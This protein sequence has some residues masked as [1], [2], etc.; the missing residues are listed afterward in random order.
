MAVVVNKKE[1]VIS[2]IA[3][4]NIIHIYIQLLAEL[5]QFQKKCVNKNNRKID[6]KKTEYR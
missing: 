4:F 2:E 3:L 1:Y 6:N 5:I